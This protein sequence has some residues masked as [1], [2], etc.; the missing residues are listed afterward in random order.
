MALLNP[1]IVGASANPVLA[2][3]AAA[4]GGDTVAHDPTK[5]Q[6]LVVINASAAATNVTMTV[7]KSSIKVGDQTFTRANIV[8]SVAAATTRY[9]PLT[10]EFVD[11]LGLFNITCSALATVSVGVLELDY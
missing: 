10:S 7:Q 11:A 8:Q 5:K 9:F 3:F 2:V 4:A 1:T 6:V